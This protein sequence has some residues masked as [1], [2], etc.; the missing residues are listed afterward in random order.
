MIRACRVGVEKRMSGVSCNFGE[1]L[2]CWGASWGQAVAVWGRRTAGWFMGGGH[3]RSL[4]L[5]QNVA[6][7]FRGS[8]CGEQAEGPRLFD[9]ITPTGDSEFAVDRH[10][11][12]LDRVR[13]DEQPLA[14]LGE[15]QVG[16]EQRQQSQLGRCE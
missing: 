16:G 10:R 6:E 2:S 9:S 1:W 12:R 3:P 11:L 13:R 5:L 8:L 15:C 4:L 14:D 7:A